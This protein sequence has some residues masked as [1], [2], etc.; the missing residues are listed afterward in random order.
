MPDYGVDTPEWKPLP[1]SWAAER[2]LGARNI[3]VVTVSADGRPHAQ[4]GWG[5][6]DEGDHRFG[7]S[8]GPR[9]RRL[10]NL[11]ANPAAVIMTESTVECLSIEGRAARVTD[12][13]RQDQWVERYLAKYKSMAPDLTADFIR[14]NVLVEFEPER[15]FAV[16]ETEEEFSTRATRWVF[17]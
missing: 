6:W 10:R 16:I 3:W 14:Q 11:A 17:G 15:A 4:P 2:L 12:G 13:A 7:F 9:S 5:V 1:W 8:S